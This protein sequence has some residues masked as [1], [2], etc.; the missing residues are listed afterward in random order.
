MLS[1][2][3]MLARRPQVLLI[4]ELSLGL[5]PV[6]VERLLPVIRSFSSESQLGRPV[7]SSSKLP[8]L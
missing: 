5:A 3:R 2:G 1:L 7:A 4:D 8:F 6:I